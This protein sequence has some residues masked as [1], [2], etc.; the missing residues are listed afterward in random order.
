MA[1]C[2]IYGPK[3]W[4]P[5]TH[6][7][8]PSSCCYAIPV[9]GFC[10]EVDSYESGCFEKLETF[11]EANSQLIIWGAIG[12]AI[13]QVCRD[14]FQLINPTYLNQNQYKFYNI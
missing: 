14:I 13:I 9:D 2:G 12:F 5:V 10:T 3:D 7:K 4:K 6:D 11:L 1:C 8:L